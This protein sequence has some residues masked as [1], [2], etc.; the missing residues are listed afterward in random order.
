[1]TAIYSR[2]CHETAGS[3]QQIFPAARTKRDHCG[4]DALLDLGQPLW[5]RLRGVSTTSG[6]LP[7]EPSNVV[8]NPGGLIWFSWADSVSKVI[9]FTR[10]P[11]RTRAE[12]LSPPPRPV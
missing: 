12:A 4:S 11:S 1:M 8:S 9:G 10:K 3:R 6:S 2:P 5:P 7:Y